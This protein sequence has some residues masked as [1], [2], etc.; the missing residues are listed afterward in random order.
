[1]SYDLPT[2]REVYYLPSGTYGATTASK[3]IVGPAGKRGTVRD[4]LMI[5]SADNVG[6]TTVP[7]ITVGASAG[8]IEYARFRLG[9]TAILGYTAAAGPRRARSLVDN[10][11]GRT[12]TPPPV[13]SDFVGHVALETAKIPADTA[14]VISGKAGVGGTPAGTFEAYVTIDW[15]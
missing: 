13:L 1:M 9:T 15:D 4:I 5:P 10:A 2:R 11:Q 14:F 12:G 6:T 8:A 7:E 3:T